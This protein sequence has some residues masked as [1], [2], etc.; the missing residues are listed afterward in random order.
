MQPCRIPYNCVCSGVILETILSE[1]YINMGVIL[2]SYRVVGNRET[3]LFKSGKQVCFN[4]NYT[5]CMYVSLHII[6]G[7]LQRFVKM[8]IHSSKTY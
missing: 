4:K 2:Q 5:L 6:I 1:K 7:F 3:Q 8:F